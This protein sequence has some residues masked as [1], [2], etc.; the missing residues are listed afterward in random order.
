[1]YLILVLTFKAIHRLARPYISDLI[2]VRPKSS[3]YLRSN[4][5]LLLEPPKEKMLATLGA[6]S[7]YAA[8]PCL[9]NSLPPELR[10]VRSINIFKRNLKTHLS[11]KFFSVLVFIKIVRF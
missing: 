9:W 2:S 1:M 6:R 4:S 7:F 11:V 8:V 5:S 3:Y 10:D